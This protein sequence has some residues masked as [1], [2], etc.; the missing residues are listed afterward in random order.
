MLLVVLVFGGVKPSKL[1]NVLGSH[2]NISRLSLLTS[3][4]QERVKRSV[5]PLSENQLLNEAAQ[6]KAEDMKQRNYWSH[7]TPDGKQPWVFVDASKYSYD[8][9]G[10]NLAYGFMSSDATVAGW[11]QSPSHRE[12]MLDN[13]YTEVGFGIAEASGYQGGG[14]ET[15]VV[16]FYAAPTNKQLPAVQSSNAD[17]NAPSNQEP[18]SFIASITDSQATWASFVVGIITGISAGFL[19]ARHSLRLKRI[20]SSGEHFIMHHPILD[21]SMTGI[22]VIGVLLLQTAGYV[23]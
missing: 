20:I 22:V 23:G 17:T 16:A 10:E 5:S 2:T 19:I 9:A 13:G 14:L 11:M 18:V 8:K 21:L 12:N 15:I 4:N 1:G 3:T 7:E 6:A